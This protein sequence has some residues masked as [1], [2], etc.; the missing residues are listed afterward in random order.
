MIKYLALTLLLTPIALLPSS[1]PAF[2]LAQER[3]MNGMPHQPSQPIADSS[4]RN[5]ASSSLTAMRENIEYKESEPLYT[6]DEDAKILFELVNCLLNFVP[7]GCERA[8]KAR[9]LNRFFEAIDAHD[10]RTISAM[11]AKDIQL[12]FAIDLRRKYRALLKTNDAQTLLNTYYNVLPTTDRLDFTFYNELSD[13]ANKISKAPWFAHGDELM[14]AKSLTFRLTKNELIRWNRAETELPDAIPLSVA[15]GKELYGLHTLF[16]SRDALSQASVGG[17]TEIVQAMLDALVNDVNALILKTEPSLFGDPPAEKVFDLL[18]KICGSL[19]VLLHCSSIAKSSEKCQKAAAVLYK[20]LGLPTTPHYENY[21]AI[22]RKL[23]RALLHTAI[24]AEKYWFQKRTELSAMREAGRQ[25]PL[26]FDVI[27]SRDQSPLA[28]VFENILCSAMRRGT[29]EM[30]QIIGEEIAAIKRDPRNGMHQAIDSRLAEQF[31]QMAM[32]T[33]NGEKLG[34]LLS[35]DSH[36]ESMPYILAMG[37]LSHV[38]KNPRLLARLKKY[39]R[40]WQTT[41]ELIAEHLLPAL[42][43]CVAQYD[44]HCMPAETQDYILNLRPVIPALQLAEQPANDNEGFLGDHM[45]SIMLEQQRNRGN[46]D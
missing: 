6:S 2:N 45:A 19:H 39:I 40:K 34:I 41:N 42:A 25:I 1:Q 26:H 21:P 3:K 20:H 11:A 35:I 30:L 18:P 9:A 7:F 4:V 12:I 15:H 16:A 38:E 24:A 44:S 31:K 14:N 17:H 23:L 36:P 33:V 43:P 8:V 22:T 13:L 46:N 28:L 32:E 27:A 5:T 10:V 29:P 37:M